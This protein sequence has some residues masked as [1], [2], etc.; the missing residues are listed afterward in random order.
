[1]EERDSQTEE[2]VTLI[3]NTKRFK[4]SKKKLI[5]NSRY[6]SALFSTTFTD[7]RLSEHIINYEI[8]LTSF[9]DFINWINSDKHDVTL[10]TI[11]NNLER[12]LILLEL[13]VLF[14]V[15]HLIEDIT[16]ILERNYLLPED[17]LNIWLLAEE[18]GLN[19]LR[20]LSLSVCLDRFSELPLNLIYKLARENFLKLVGNINL[21]VAKDAKV[22]D[23]EDYLFCIAQEW[24]KINQ[25]TI[26]LDILKKTGPKVYKS[27]ISFDNSNP[28]NEFYIH[29]WDGNK[30]FEFTTFKYPEA[31][32][33]IYNNNNTL[34]GMQFAIRGHNLYL[35]GGEFLIGSGIFNKYMWRYSLIS[36]KWF[37]ETAI[38]CARRHMIAAFVQ[39]TLLLAGGVGHYRRKL[40]SLDIYN[41]HEGIWT[42]GMSLPIEFVT[43]PDYNVVNNYLIVYSFFPT[44]GR[45]LPVIYIYN[46]E[47]NDWHKVTISHELELQI[48]DLHMT[49]S[50]IK[51]FKTASC[52]IASNK[53]DRIN[54][55]N[56]VAV[57]DNLE[58]NRKIY[59]KYAKFCGIKEEE[60]K[61]SQNLYF[62]LVLSYHND[63]YENYVL[64]CPKHLNMECALMWLQEKKNRL[65]WYSMPIQDPNKFRFLSSRS[66]T[67]FFNLMD[68][69]NLCINSATNSDDTS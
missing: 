8:P 24:M 5:K 67:T 57:C 30:F 14:A 60:E 56:I 17:V 2:I 46:P 1:M 28:D 64:I 3:L 22:K 58:H 15:D 63:L 52:Y 6:F 25:D 42:K 39:N 7:Y 62:Y 47:W 53:P 32:K 10:P 12:L 31:I 20:D 37:L 16:D 29:C 33:K 19:I 48:H 9:E 65:P 11:Q 51:Q 50:I 66:Y 38:P 44:N 61:F 27:I 43:P 21:R 23:A 13:S 18:L 69:A 36:K 68:P 45:E 26:P 41:V 49:A 4:I 55:K 59:E 35:C 34:V 54:L 40:R